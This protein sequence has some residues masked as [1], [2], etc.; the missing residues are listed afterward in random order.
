MTSWFTM[1]M[2]ILICSNNTVISCLS[3]LRTL[4]VSR[5]TA[6]LAFPK[7]HR[8]VLFKLQTSTRLKI[9]FEQ[10]MEAVS[11]FNFL[12]LS[13]NQWQCTRGALCL[14]LSCPSALSRAHLTIPSTAVDDQGQA[15]GCIII[16]ACANSYQSLPLF[17]NILWPNHEWYGVRPF[18][19]R[20]ETCLNF[21]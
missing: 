19:W 20:N 14:L 3:S 10:I 6:N 21:W 7:C 18:P 11:V 4:T 8:W 15:Y 2:V 13:Y 16:M 9:N 17:Y 12:R 5:L 1:T